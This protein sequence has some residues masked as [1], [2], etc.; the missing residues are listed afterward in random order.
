M[1]FKLFCRH[2]R[3]DA[4]FIGNIFGDLI[5]TCSPMRWF[6]RDKIMRSAWCCNK[7]GKVFFEERFG[8]EGYPSLNESLAA[9]D[10]IEKEIKL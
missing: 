9:L 7:C 5:Y 2:S 1:K 3:D 8:P 10:L 4:V 6:G